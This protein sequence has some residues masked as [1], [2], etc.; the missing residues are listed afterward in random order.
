MLLAALLCASFQARIN[1][2]HSPA[3][4][5]VRTR[6]PLSDTKVY[7]TKNC[8]PSES[9]NFL[10]AELQDFSLQKVY[11]EYHP[12]NMTAEVV[13]VIVVVDKKEKFLKKLFCSRSASFR[14]ADESENSSPSPYHTAKTTITTDT[15]TPRKKLSPI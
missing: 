6:H 15:Q 8:F 5:N 9:W 10:A 4:V 2:L 7:S 13:V 3:N 11:T 12:V 14:Q 1:K